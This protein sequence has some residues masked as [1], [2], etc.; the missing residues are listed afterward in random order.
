MGWKLASTE[1]FSSRNAAVAPMYA[2][3]L[4][5]LI[6]VAGVGWDYSRL[7]TMDSELQNAADQ[8]ALAAATQLT[9]VPGAMA[10]AEAA[11]EDYLATTGSAW[12]NQTKL[13]NDGKGSDITG[14]NF[15]FYEDYDHATDTPGKVATDDTK[16]RYVEVLVDGREA[17]YALTAVGGVLSSG[18][19]HADAVATLETAVCKAPKMFIC[20]PDRSFPTDADKGRG[21]LLR[22]LPN[23]TDSFTPGNFGFLDPGGDIKSERDK[24]NPNHELG[25]NGELA[26]CISS[27]GIESEPGFVAPETRALNTRFDIYGP[28][29]P[30]C[31]TSNGNYCPSQNTVSRW[32]YKIQVT[33][34]GANSVAT[35][36]CPST[37]PNNANL[38]KL[39]D[40]QAEM[41]SQTNQNPGYQRD[42]CLL[43][44]SCD[45]VG[46]GDWSG[47]DYMARN[48][49]GVDLL[50]V[51]DG[52]RHG[53]YEWERANA[54]TRLLPRKVGYTLPNGNPPKG[55]LY[56]AYPQPTDEPAWVPNATQKDRRIMTVAS[57]DCTGL[58]GRDRLD[59]LRWVDLFIVDASATTGPNAGEI[60]TEI[61]GPAQRPG[62]GYAFQSYGRKKPVLVR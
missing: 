37:P 45:A 51:S 19:I 59:I 11:A 46:D 14:L 34:G 35:A 8:A 20:A 27:T 9:G 56:C 24:G 16:A 23:A 50:S 10:A 2:L 17:Y 3:S 38:M 13:A 7:M 28:S 33:G 60:M 47:A 57:V 30:S 1:F 21:F 43:N 29:V 39:S 44:G 55:S 54:A 48:H 42:N 4:F 18:L 5:G 62:G 41:G 61:V 53:V 31:N 52:S 40:A 22:T 15:T 25:K 32:V 12:A 49:G 36:S 58:N 6:T 26:G